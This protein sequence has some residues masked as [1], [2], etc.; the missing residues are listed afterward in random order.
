VPALSGGIVGIPDRP[1]LVTDVIPT[2]PLDATNIAA[3]L[4]ETVRTHAAAEVAEGALKPTSTYTVAKVE[5]PARTIATLSEPV[6]RHDLQDADLLS[7]YVENNLSQ[8]V[9]LRLDTQI[10]SGDGT[11]PNISGCSIAPASRLRRSP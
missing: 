8:A 9:R 11:A 3:Y 7:A 1:A 6:N 4:Q 5:E 10:V 2:V